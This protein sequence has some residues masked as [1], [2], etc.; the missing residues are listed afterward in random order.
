MEQVV[1][2]VD[3]VASASP[4]LPQRQTGHPPFGMPPDGAERRRS[5]LTGE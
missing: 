1:L 4:N 2:W 3:L 5:C